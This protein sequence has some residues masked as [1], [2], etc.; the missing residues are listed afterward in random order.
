VHWQAVPSP[1]G[2]T[3]AP[4]SGSF[5]LTPSSSGTGHSRSCGATAPA[6]QA[7]SVTASVAG[8]YALRIHLTTS[9]GL[10]LPPVVVDLQVQG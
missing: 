4:S 3:V 9:G 7:L 6:T 10:T 5:T 8:S 2:L 1:S